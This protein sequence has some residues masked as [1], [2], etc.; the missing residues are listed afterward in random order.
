MK[1]MKTRYYSIHDVL[2]FIIIDKTN[3]KIFD[4][5]YTH[6]STFEVENKPERID[7]VITLGNFKPDNKGKYQVGYGKYYVDENYFYVKKESYKSAKWSFEIKGINENITKVNIDFNQSG[8][9]FITGNVIDFMIHFKLLGK[10]YPI[11]HASGISK[12][13][14]GIVFSGRGGS[15]KTSIA[16]EFLNYGFDF[17]GDNYIILNEG[18]IFNFLTS[19][20]LFTYNLNDMVL[21]KL[22]L[23]E[24]ASIKF[25]DFLYKISGGY[26]KFF[27]KINPNRI[28]NNVVST[29]NLEKVFLIQPIENFNEQISINEIKRDIAIKKILYNQMLEFTFFNQYIEIYSFFYPDNNLSKHWKLYQNSINQNLSEES[30]FYEILL[31]SEFKKEGIV[32]QIKKYI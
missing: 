16:F 10:S 23:N 11:I 32:D 12:T 3:F 29:S 6:Y 15:G 20:S 18:S 19:L 31:S 2:N 21:N 22:K 17:L 8:R 14:K 4:T 1:N 25:K 5:L 26:A 28:I 24:K 27:T 30:I 9:I 13:G 7:L